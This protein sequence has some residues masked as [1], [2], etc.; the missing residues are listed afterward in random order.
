MVVEVV[1]GRFWYFQSTAVRRRSNTD[2]LSGISEED[3]AVR[4]LI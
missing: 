2:H 1:L 3:G 4:T